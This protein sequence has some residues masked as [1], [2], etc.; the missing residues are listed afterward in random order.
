MLIIALASCVDPKHAAFKEVLGLPIPEALATL[1][2]GLRDLY[3][4]G[5]R[6]VGCLG[7]LVSQGSVAS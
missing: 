3:F 6:T 7:N 5:G 4:L 2:W 1:S